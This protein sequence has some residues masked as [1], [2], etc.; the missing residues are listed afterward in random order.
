MTVSDAAYNRELIRLASSM[1]ASVHNADEITSAILALILDGKERA[2][3]NAPRFLRTWWLYP[4]SLRSSLPGRT[5]LPCGLFG[6]TSHVVKSRRQRSIIERTRRPFSFDNKA[7]ITED[8]DPPALLRRP[9]FCSKE[10]AVRHESVGAA[11]SSLLAFSSSQWPSQAAALRKQRSFPT[12]LAYGRPLA[13]GVRSS[14]RRYAG[15]TIERIREDFHLQASEH[16]RHARS[17]A[18]NSAAPYSVTHLAAF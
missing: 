7:S 10:G 18:A 13:G 2:R 14:H 8:L 1:G 3:A 17:R 12:A 6:E 15:W 4:S 5:R 9:R 16:A 11:H